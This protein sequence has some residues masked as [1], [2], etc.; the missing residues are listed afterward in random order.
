MPAITKAPE[1]EIKVSIDTDQTTII[2]LPDEHETVVTFSPD[3]GVTLYTDQPVQ[4]AQ[5]DADTVEGGLLSFID[6]LKGVSVNGAT[7]ETAADRLIAA[8]T[9]GDITLKPPAAAPGYVE[10]LKIGQ[11]VDG[12]I[13]AGLSPA[14]GKEM[15]V[16]LADEG[17]M[18]F[19]KARRIARRKARKT[20]Q[21]YHLPTAWEA[22]ELFNN[23]AKAG[24]GGF[25]EEKYWTSSYYDYACSCITAIN[26]KNGFREE[27]KKRRK[28]YVR[29]MHN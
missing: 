28:H 25:K 5:A 18:S 22:R 17:T 14:T 12:A 13:F 1:K 6:G 19:R 11:V 27:E 16:D 7:V 20:G 24:I 23:L 29:L 3:G 15:F 9:S 21:N 4:P 2:T 8:V 10:K 26:F